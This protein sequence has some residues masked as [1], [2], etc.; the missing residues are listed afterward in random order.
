MVAS[1]EAEKVT[2]H[3]PICAMKTFVRKMNLGEN[4]VMRV[5]KITIIFSYFLNDERRIFHGSLF[6]FGDIQN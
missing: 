2:E 6:F 4:K 3:Q 1:A 5:A